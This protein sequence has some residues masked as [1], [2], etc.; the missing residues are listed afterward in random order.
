MGE[1]ANGRFVAGFFL[2]I[3]NDVSAAPTKYGFVEGW[4]DPTFGPVPKVGGRY[5]S[6]AAGN[7]GYPVPVE[8]A[9]ALNDPVLCR[10]ADGLGGLAWE[11]SPL[12]PSSRA[13]LY[14]VDYVTIN[15]LP[16]N[17]YN[18]G[19]S[20]VGA[21]LTG[22]TSGPLVLSNAY[23]GAGLLRPPAG[24]LILVNGEA[25]C[26]QLTADTANES[27]RAG[28]SRTDLLH[29]TERPPRTRARQI[30]LRPS[31]APV[32]SMTRLAGLL[33][34]QVGKCPLVASRSLGLNGSHGHQCILSLK[35]CFS[36][37]RCRAWT[38]R[39]DRIGFGLPRTD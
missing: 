5:G 13:A 10:Q 8:T 26:S 6:I 37:S 24:T 12:K 23:Y 27:D 3:I 28:L 38:E 32:P 34:S 36:L 21:T 9:F 20:G 18:N 15:P 16:A 14:Q 1:T 22:T 4:I 25:N 7:P 30:E 2:G 29:S 19:S 39:T 17:T 33:I 35:G 11:L 31:A